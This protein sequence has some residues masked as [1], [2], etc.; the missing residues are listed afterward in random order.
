MIFLGVNFR[1][2]MPVYNGFIVIG[3]DSSN[4]T[5][6][7]LNAITDT[8]SNVLIFVQDFTGISAYNNNMGTANKIEYRTTPYNQLVAAMP[9]YSTAGPGGV[10]TNKSSLLFTNGS[11]STWSDT[12]GVPGFD[13]TD[14]NITAGDQIVMRRGYFDGSDNTVVVGLNNVSGANQLLYNKDDISTTWSSILAGGLASVD[15]IRTIASRPGTND[16]WI[17]VTTG[18]T[19]GTII[20]YKSGISTFSASSG[21]NTQWIQDSDTI[22]SGFGK[23]GASTDGWIIAGNVQNTIQDA[24][25]LIQTSY[26][27]GS[28]G[29]T[30]YGGALFEVQISITRYPARWNPRC[31]ATDNAGTW[32][33]GYS[34]GM[35]TGVNP[36]GIMYSTDYGQTF[37]DSSFNAFFPISTTNCTYECLG[38]AYGVV[39]GQ[40]YFVASGIFYQGS[41]PLSNYSILQST[42][43]TSWFPSDIPGSFSFGNGITNDVIYTQMDVVCLLKGSK[44]K[45][46]EG[47]VQIET[48]KQGDTI[49]M[50]NGL[51]REIVDIPC[52]TVPNEPHLAPYIIPAGKL[53]ATEDLYLSPTHSVFIDGKFIEAQFLGY[54]RADL[55]DRFFEYYNIS[56]GGFRDELLDAQGVTIESHGKPFKGAEKPFHEKV[57]VRKDLPRD[58]LY[59]EDVRN[60]LIAK[61]QQESPYTVSELQ[62]FSDQELRYI[63]LGDNIELL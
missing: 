25:S 21:F 32:V 19:N 17:V 28:G 55:T 5:P 60:G 40:G 56:L 20:Y 53:G 16:N 59:P 58:T 8:V 47:Y 37:I 10:G 14:A 63:L 35:T 26:L 36:V 34:A 11:T 4:N 27:D 61:L 51:E 18:N 46:P 45:T 3:Q 33:I 9:L 50:P 39:D 57:A 54:K 42:N 44:I 38:L 24:S 43:G 22:A 49:L 7:V 29:W 6:V 13:T 48:L 23:I 30:A 41:T 12:S 62:N 15:F 52:Q 31:I 2:K 1:V